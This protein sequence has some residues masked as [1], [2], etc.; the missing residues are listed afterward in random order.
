MI[1]GH[2]R[3]SAMSS[4]DRAHTISY[5]SLIE[6][7]PLSCTVFEIWRAICR[8]SPTSTYPRSNFEKIVGIRKLES[9]GYHAALFASSCV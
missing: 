2:P 4:F 6:T 8:N 9:L 5:S 1:R 7:M 3:S